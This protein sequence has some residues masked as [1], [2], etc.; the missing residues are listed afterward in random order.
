MTRIKNSKYNLSQPAY[1]KIPKDMYNKLVILA[2]EKRHWSEL[3]RDIV[4][5]WV[6]MYSQ[7]EGA[8]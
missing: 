8:E 7:G 2:G 6:T 3:T 1:L 4:D 5:A